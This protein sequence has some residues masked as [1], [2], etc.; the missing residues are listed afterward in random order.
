MLGLK[1]GEVKLFPHE[2]EWE[3]EAARTIEKLRLVLGSSAFGIEHVGS[4]SIET[5]A[6][7]PIIDIAVETDSFE[8]IIALKD[9]L[10]KNGFYLR[11][12]GLKN[13]LLLACGSFYDK[14]GDSQTHFIHVVKRN[15]KEWND[16]INFKNYLKK[17]PQAAKE[18]EKLKLEL[19]KTASQSDGRKEYTDGKNALIAYFLRKAL[20]DSYLGKTVR[21]VIDR[22]IGYVHKKADFSLTYPINYGYIPDV[23]GGDGEELD[24]Y[25][26]GVD[27]PVSSY[28]AKIIA[29][30]HRKN[31]VEDKL[32][33]APPEKLFTK[34]EIA[35]SGAFQE[36]YFDSYVQII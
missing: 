14:T 10:Q 16:Y 2:K 13:Q 8:N 3:Q 28:T 17:Y 15:S 1:R 29:V 30:V 31:D 32:V 36:L 9:K 24:V 19:S 35:S 22:P 27:K 23:I 4:T 12:C 21:I 6:A 25:L 5:I 18:Y 34:D 11:D 7:K 26:L 20:A 33:A